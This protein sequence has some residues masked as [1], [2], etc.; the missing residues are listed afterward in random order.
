VDGAVL[1]LWGV[2]RRRVLVVLSRGEEVGGCLTVVAA[3]IWH[4]VLGDGGEVGDGVGNGV[5]AAESED[6]ARIGGRVG[7]GN[8]AARVG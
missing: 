8:V 7:E 5:G 1:A 2:R 3:R 6:K 4:I